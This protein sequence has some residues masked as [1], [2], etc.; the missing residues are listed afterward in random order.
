MDKTV[1]LSEIT[2]NSGG[3][4]YNAVIEGE[5][6]I[7]NLTKDFNINSR[8][9][10]LNYRIL[11]F[12]PLSK[13]TNISHMLFLFDELFLLDG[14]QVYMYDEITK[15][16]HKVYFPPNIVSIHH[17]M[18][19]AKIIALTSD[20]DCLSQ[21]TNIK[22][23]SSHANLE[24]PV[25]IKY[26]DFVTEI[27]VDINNKIYTFIVDNSGIRI[28]HEIGKIDTHTHKFKIVGEYLLAD[29]NLHTLPTL[30]IINTGIKLAAGSGNTFN[31][32]I[33]LVSDDN[34]LSLKRGVDD[35]KQIHHTITGE[36]IDLQ[37][38][39]ILIAIKVNDGNY[40]FGHL[41]KETFIIDK[42]VSYFQPRLY[43]TKSA[44][45][46]ENIKY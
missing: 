44:Q 31:N 36:I 37:M 34:S 7:V 18:L 8:I 30:N 21:H 32:V 39:N 4:F 41:K 40:Y 17:D 20:G 23:W 1:L 25:K 10:K 35:V 9:N 29:N 24:F 33:L 16:V 12:A 11:D 19:Y 15:L 45:K 42:I 38:A 5:Y 26:I 46:I 14:G 22:F 43:N 2:T 3:L 27:L 28:S 6:A 13:F